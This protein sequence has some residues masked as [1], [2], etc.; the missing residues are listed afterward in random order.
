MSCPV[1]GQ[2]RETLALPFAVG[3]RRLDGSSHSSPFFLSSLIVP[4]NPNKLSTQKQLRCCATKKTS[5]R[6]V[7]HRAAI[8]RTHGTE[9]RTARE[10]LEEGAVDELLVGLREVNL[11]Q[12][13]FSIVLHN[14][15]QKAR[16]AVTTLIKLFSNNNYMYFIDN[17][18]MLCTRYLYLYYKWHKSCILLH[19]AFISENIICLYIYIYF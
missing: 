16:L 11:H 14:N 13:L 10:S 8:S 6:L 2:S 7:L 19:L 12:C 5:P 18:Y 4:F 3:D 17:K 9:C 1:L 15:E